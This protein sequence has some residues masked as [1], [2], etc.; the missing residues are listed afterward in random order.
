MVSDTPYMDD[1]QQL[2]PPTR[3]VSYSSSLDL[4][5]LLGFDQEH[6]MAKAYIEADGD[7]VDIRIKSSGPAGLALTEF[8]MGGSPVALSFVAIPVKP[9]TPATD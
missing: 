4:P 8:L 7:N 3:K 1:M 2:P 9:H 6:V 5:V